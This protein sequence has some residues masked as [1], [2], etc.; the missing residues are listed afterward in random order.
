M[1]TKSVW[2]SSGKQISFPALTTDITVDIVIIGGGITGISAAYLLSKTGK[3]VAVLEAREIADGSTGYSTGNLYALVGS[4]GLHK[5]KSKWNEDVLKQVVASRTAAVDFIEERVREFNIECDFKRIPWCLFTNL[6]KQESYI[7]KEKEVI[8]I[9]GLATAN[10]IPFPLPWK[11]GFKV[12]DQAQ[13][14]PYEY[15]IG[16]AK[17]IQSNTCSIYEH[18]RATNLE[19]EMFAL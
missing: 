2:K 13:F 1:T 4:E 18:T 6:D 3:K 12:N 9:A 8:E 19:E 15:V 7:Q 5:V 16:F 11:Y 17:N 10:D 14:N